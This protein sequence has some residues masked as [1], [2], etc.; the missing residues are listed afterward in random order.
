MHSLVLLQQ[1]AESAALPAA[2]L[3]A[4][5]DAALLA[6]QPHSAANRQLYAEIQAAMQSLKLQISAAS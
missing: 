1:G 5:L 3:A 6:V 2:T 4:A